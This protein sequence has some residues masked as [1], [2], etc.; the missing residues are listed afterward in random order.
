MRRISIHGRRI[1]LEW[2][3]VGSD[4]DPVEAKTLPIVEIAS[5][6]IVRRG[7]RAVATDSEP[8]SF[9]AVQREARPLTSRTVLDPS[10][11]A[12]RAETASTINR[13]A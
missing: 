6:E 8:E 4:P 7:Q 11:P 9:L 2:P 10:L 3:P 13:A 12:L 1:D 5:D